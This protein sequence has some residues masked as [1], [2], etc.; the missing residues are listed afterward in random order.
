MSKITQLI[1]NLALKFS[2]ATL[3]VKV[4]REHRLYYSF[5]AEILY[6]EIK[7]SMRKR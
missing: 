3:L 1:I 4:I 7:N 5:D 2:M 6:T